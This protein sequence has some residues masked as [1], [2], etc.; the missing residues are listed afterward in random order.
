MLQQGDGKNRGGDI[1]YFAIIAAA[2]GAVLL[3]A[4]GC[5]SANPTS[6]ASITSPIPPVP[7]KGKLYVAV[8]GTSDLQAGSGNM[9]LAIV[10]IATRHVEMVNLP[11]AKAPHGI[12][13]TPG[14]RT[15]PG[16]QGR[17]ALEAPAGVLLGDAQDGRVLQVDLAS[18]SVTRTIKPPPNAKLSI[19]GMDTFTDGTIYLS[20]MADGMVYPL[21]FKAGRIGAPVAGGDGVSSSICSIVWVNGGKAAY[22]DNMFDPDHPETAGY[23]AKIQWPGGRLIKKV[24]DVTRPAPGGESLSHQMAATPDGKYLYVADSID[25]KL[26]KIDTTN[27]QIIK[28][29][30]AG[31]EPRS[32]VFSAD[33]RLAYIAVCHEPV[34][35]ESSV[36]VYDVKK[37]EVV[38]RI[39]AIPAPLV[40]GIVLAET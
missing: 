27:D 11:A 38:A 26:V 21:D 37:D 6:V 34:D 14:T 33:G 30:P 10:D 22:I 7:G 36:F 3:L 18:R 4:A 25:G 20:S 35:N 24:E 16:S 1:K 9:G 13:F 5:G 17:T 19:C 32:I 15:A 39:P 40:C 12:A 29:V 28:S 8:T 31:K 2:L 23:L